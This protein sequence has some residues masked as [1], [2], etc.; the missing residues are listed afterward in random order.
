M[1]FK[2]E[3]KKEYKIRSKKIKICHV[4]YP[5]PS[6]PTPIIQVTVAMA[7]IHPRHN[8]TLPPLETQHHLDSKS[9]PS[10]QIC[11]Y[12]SN[13]KSLKIPHA[14]FILGFKL[15]FSLLREL[16]NVTHLVI[17]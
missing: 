7:K 9:T 4:D 2:K 11:Q 14:H 16:G 10:S 17:S 6:P 1:S 12:Q 5:F 15:K 13:T 3:K 8:S